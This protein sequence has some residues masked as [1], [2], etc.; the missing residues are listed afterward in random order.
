ME[1]SIKKLM[2]FI[3]L[4]GIICYSNASYSTFCYN[5]K[6]AFHENVKEDFMQ[7]WIYVDEKVEGKQTLKSSFSNS[8]S[9]G[10]LHLFSHGKPGQLL[11]EGSWLS[12]ETISQWIYQNYHD[13][14][15]NQINIY[16]CEFGKGLE[17]KYAVDFLE[18]SLNIS[19]S[20]SDN[21][22]GI[23]GDW[24]LEVGKH[25]V[26]NAIVGYK[27]NLQCSGQEGDCDGDGVLDINDRDSDNDGILDSD[28]I[29]CVTLQSSSFSALITAWQSTSVNVI[30]GRSYQVNTPTSSQGIR[31]ITGGPNDG[32]T[33][34]ATQFAGNRFS[35]LDG[36]G[37]FT[38]NNNYEVGPRASEAIGFAN[39]L[40]ADYP[41]LLTYIGMVDTNGNNQFDRGTDEIIPVLFSET[42]NITFTPT[43]SGVLHVV[44]TDRE[45]ADNNNSIL[46]FVVQECTFIDTDDDGIPDYLDLDSDNDGCPDAIEGGASFTY[47]DLNPMT[48][49]SGGIDSNGIPSVISPEGQSIGFSRVATQIN[50]VSP[51]NDATLVNNGSASFTVTVSATNSTTFSSG[52]P[53]YDSPDGTDTSGR[54]IFRWQESNDNGDNWSNINDGGIFSG[55]STKTLTIKDPEISYNG[56]LFRVRITHTDYACETFSDDAT[57]FRL[58]PVELLSFEG[59][60][61][62]TNQ[63]LLTWSTAKERDSKKF[64][65]QRSNNANSWI[66]LGSIEA[67]GDSDEVNFYEF[68]DNQPMAGNNYYRLVQLDFDGSSD[69]SKV[70]R[71]EFNPIWSVKV[72]PNP[73]AKEIFIQIKNLGEI[74]ISLMDNYGRTIFSNSSNTEDYFF[75][76]DTKDLHNGLYFLKITRGTESFTYKLRK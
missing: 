50:I 15:I 29:E 22:T 37:Y 58:L 28:E 74:H 62:N 32:R 55:A 2:F 33:I 48:R 51:P 72:Y 5:P 42:G 10:V 71:V 69:I 21:I 8:N 68:V 27:Y 20:A 53:N 6:I 70:I 63:S 64:I 1:I 13:Q 39:L 31:T 40:P 56:Y 52:T 59:K 60:L 30:A 43:V 16:G 25:Q 18:S 41:R 54:L 3:I 76:F 65:V 46:N 49:L 36:I 12:A 34:T 9:Q 19:I 35:D 67:Q 17:G 47:F 61:T 44:Y 45:Y 73:F 75:Q 7:P 11:L 4:N 57:L 38:T 23:D 14:V 26:I 66:N 24:I